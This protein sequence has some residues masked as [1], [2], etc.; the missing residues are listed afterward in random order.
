MISYNK[1]LE[2]LGNYDVVVVGGGV[3]GI[4]AAIEASR[5]GASVAIIEKSLTLGGMLTSGHVS[6][7]LGNFVKNTMA[8]ELLQKV[9]CTYNSGRSHDIEEM[10]IVIARLVDE[11]GVSTYLGASIIDVIKNNNIITHAVFSTQFGLK[12]ITGKVS[13]LD[14]TWRRCFIVSCR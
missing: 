13:F 8:D 2:N 3:A 10:K 6:P 4:G 5:Q 11:I 12:T 1:N 9:K 14:C 7:P